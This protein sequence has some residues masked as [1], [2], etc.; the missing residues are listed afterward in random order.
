MTRRHTLSRHRWRTLA[1]IAATATLLAGLAPTGAAAG[2]GTESGNASE[3]TFT[4]TVLHNNDGESELVNLGSGLEDFG[5]AA[6]FATVVR[7][8]KMRALL[9]HWDRDTKRGVIMVSSGDNF[10]AGPEFTASTTNGIYYDAIALDLIG[11]DAIDIGNH[12][13][14]FGPDVLADFIESYRF[15]RS[16]TYLSA[17]LDFSGEPRLQAL[18]DEGK[19]AKSVVVH[20]RGEW[21]GIVGATTPNLRFISS[22][23]NVVVDPDVVGAVQAEIDKLEA[24]GV[25]KIVFLS[26]LQDVEG[27]VAL[28]SE[29]TGVDVAVAGGGD[30]LLANPDDLLVPGDEGEVFG[31]YPLIAVSGD[32][33]NIPVVTTSGQYGYLG[34]L[35]VEFDS[36]GNVIRVDDSS[37]PIRIAG[38][39]NPDAV[40]P[41]KRMMRLV[42][43]PVSDF[44]AGLAENIVGTSEVDL[45]GRRSSVRAVESNEGNLI[46]DSQLW[47]ARELAA[48]FGVPAP[49]V[50]LQNGGGIRNDS[51][52]PAGPISELDTFSMV[53]F[54][55]FVTIVPD[56]PRD[57]FK[58]I[59]ENAVS[60]IDPPAAPGGTGRFAQVAGFSFTFDT[61]GTPLLFDDTGVIVQNGTRVNE[62][63][64]DDGTVIVTGGVVLPGAPITIAIVDFLA[65]GGDEYPFM[66][67]AFTAIGVSYQQAL[68]N[69]IQGPL[70]GVISAADYPVGG[71]GRITQLP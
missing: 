31:P 7:N 66:G 14:D 62:V 8:E 35:V 49:D 3:R 32:G 18:A 37:G 69:Y 9:P 30:E 11:Y 22:P 15:G 12:D 27:D 53:P 48:D 50:A 61:T 46:A 70:G 43:N 19:I 54:P 17:N 67:A 24:M 55:N 13:F 58:L 45:D 6:R 39:D 44:V 64:L 59:M 60:R 65:R 57:Q 52:I 40:K 16:E 25:N 2:E 42:T 10:L 21:I 63:V 1:T 33:A 71:E 36:E 20:E 28:M 5:G 38:G 34:K 68:S 41:N 47:Q 23:R 26:H 56:I 4:L 51:I 29:L